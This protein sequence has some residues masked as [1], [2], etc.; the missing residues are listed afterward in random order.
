MNKFL[1]LKIK[2]NNKDEKMVLP[3]LNLT[4]LFW[5]M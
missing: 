1:T 5:S 3:F 2:T 4:V